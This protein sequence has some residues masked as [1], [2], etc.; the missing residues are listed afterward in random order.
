MVVSLFNLW[1]VYQPF[2]FPIDATDV[3]FKICFT[4]IVFVFALTK[5]KRK[6]KNSKDR[7]IKKQYNKRREEKIR[8]EKII[9]EARQPNEEDAKMDR[10]NESRRSIYRGNSGPTMSKEAKLH[11]ASNRGKS[12][13]TMSKEAKLH[14]GSN[15]TFNLDPDR[16]PSGIARMTG[17]KGTA[18]HRG[19]FTA[20]RAATA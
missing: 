19:P 6:E 3:C 15:A 11:C 17:G 12:G 8:E 4:L 10:H 5:E 7:N 20:G 1:L 14:C 9:K 16:G 18:L 2:N 13:S